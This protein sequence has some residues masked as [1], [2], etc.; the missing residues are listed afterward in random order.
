[1]PT[2]QA[3]QTFKPA[4]CKLG[5]GCVHQGGGDSRAARRARHEELIK[6]ITAQDEK[7]VRRAGRADHEGVGERR[8]EPFAETR[9]RARRDEPRR[10]QMRVPVMPGV[11]PDAREVIELLMHSQGGWRPVVEALDA[12]PL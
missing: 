7:P 8:R 11:V 12:P 4:P 1:M 10:R 3:S 5:L 2:A 6:L 9:N